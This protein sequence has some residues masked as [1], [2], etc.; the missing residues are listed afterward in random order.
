[1]NAELPDKFRQR[2]DEAVSPGII[3]NRLQDWHEGNHPG[4]ALATLARWCRIR[5]YLDTAAAHG[6]TA[7]DA[8]RD[9]FAGKPPLPPTPVLS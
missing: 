1:M 3:H 8:I 2:Y 7:L 9:A 5:S 4:Y 6:I